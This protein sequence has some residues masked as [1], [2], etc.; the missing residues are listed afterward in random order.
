MFLKMNKHLLCSNVSEIVKSDS[1]WEYFIPKQPTIFQYNTN[2]DD[3][4]DIEADEEYEA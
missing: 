4:D 3:K 1:Q 2:D